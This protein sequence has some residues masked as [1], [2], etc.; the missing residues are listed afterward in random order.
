MSARINNGIKFVKTYDIWGTIKK[1]IF[2]KAT[3][4]YVKYTYL[5]FIKFF[6]SKFK[7]RARPFFKLKKNK[8]INLNFFLVFGKGKK[9]RRNRFYIRRLLKK[10]RKL[11]KLKTKQLGS[12]YGRKGRL[13][14]EL[15]RFKA[16][17]FSKIRKKKL[18]RYFQV[19]KHI[20]NHS[21]DNLVYHFEGM[22]G[23]FLMRMNFFYSFYGLKKILKF[24]LFEI[25]KK[26][27]TSCFYFF[28]PSDILCF[29][30]SFFKY[31]KNKFLRNIKKRKS[32]F[33]IPANL[34][35]NYKYLW[36][37][38]FRYPEYSKNFNINF[39]DMRYRFLT[40]SWLNLA[41]NVSRY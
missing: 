10:N 33:M 24:G 27:V 2:K 3:N 40:P 34:E 12:R 28:L 39:S 26:L 22:L 36:F 9:K 20:F 4:K 17:F 7:K 15:K 30:K 6:F 32:I 5:N 13:I 1:R 14:F 29:S 31:L 21:L 11:L 35:I 18:I 19:R 8:Y 25:N 23:V 37:N 16:F 38:Y 41:R